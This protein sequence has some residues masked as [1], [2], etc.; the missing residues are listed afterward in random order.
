MMTQREK[1]DSANGLRDR[2]MVEY[3]KD[4]AKNSAGYPKLSDL[5]GMKYIVPR[6]QELVVAP[7]TKFHEYERLGQEPHRGVVLYGASGVG[8]TYLVHCIAQ[9]MLV[10][11]IKCPT[12]DVKEIREAFRKVELIKP[13]L[14]L[15]D[16]IDRISVTDNAGEIDQ[17]VEC[18]HSMSRGVLAIA[19]AQSLAA[20]DAKL[21]TFNTFEAQILV[22]VP[23][24]VE[25]A[26][27]LRCVTKGKFSVDCDA[28]ARNTPGF[29]PADL[30]RLARAAATKCISSGLASVTNEK[31]MEAIADTRSFSGITFDDIGALDEVKEI[32]SLNVILPSLHPHAFAKM[33]ICKAS[34]VLL[35]GPPGCGK[36]MLA[37]AVSNMSHCNFISVR[38]P[39]LISKYVGDSE[40][41][42]RSLFERAKTLSPCVIFFDEIDSICSRRT[43][44]S[45]GNRIV[46]QILTLLD[47]LE[48]RGSVFVIAATNR[49]KSL[50]R[51]LLRPGRFDK[52]VEV[53]YPS[54]DECRQIFRK[55]VEKLPI[56]DID[57]N[58]LHFDR[59][60]GADVCGIVREA[61]MCAIKRD[62]AGN[63]T[64]TKEDVAT[65]FIH[66]S[67]YSPH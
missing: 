31:L 3:L 63:G 18:M 42:I 17:I 52:I 9:E 44:S 46:N 67:K 45:F 2:Y 59:C 49:L 61:A 27:V 38:G 32:L 16:D 55:A 20:V 10:P 33:G 22:H 36:T 43:S 12:K 6:V 30:A 28:A 14:V 66:R 11:V 15:I 62:P 41:E 21:K 35:H 40:K 26:E 13:A 65:A 54:Q 7:L 37:K 24:M 25:R 19:T 4:A 64:I 51:A 8:K 29:T 1:K 39:E 53:P 50:D 57:V 23:S 47:G 34:G 5:G 56:E 58:A 60:S 48:N